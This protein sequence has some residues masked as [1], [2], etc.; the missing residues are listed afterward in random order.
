L[1][2]KKARALKENGRIVLGQKGVRECV[3]SIDDAQQQ[4]ISLDSSFVK[5]IQSSVVLIIHD[6]KDEVVNASNA[7][8]F[9]KSIAKNMNS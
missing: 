8:E 3:M 6:S 2:A 9:Q 4:S 7:Q 1:G 5:N